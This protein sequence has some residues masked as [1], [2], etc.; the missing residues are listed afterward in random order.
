[1][2]VVATLPDNTEYFDEISEH[3]RTVGD[4]EEIAQRAV[5]KNGL[6]TSRSN[7]EQVKVEV[8]R[9]EIK[10]GKLTRAKLGTFNVTPPLQRMTEDEYLTE[11]KENLSSIPV[12]F[13]G[14]VE[15][16]CYE[17]GHSYGYEEVIG[18]VRDM[19]HSLGAAI[20]AY[21]GRVKP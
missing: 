4:I 3:R 13:H 10:Q 7:P 16:Y 5:S 14:F 9:L 11:L 6:T 2:Q 21:D 20:K 12:E 15:G 8:H 17:Q 1:M 18:H 19:V